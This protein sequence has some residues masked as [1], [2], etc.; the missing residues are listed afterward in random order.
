MIHA[1][2]LYSVNG[3]PRLYG[4]AAMMEAKPRWLVLRIEKSGWKVPNT[5]EKVT[6]R[7]SQ[8]VN[9]WERE[10]LLMKCK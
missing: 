8:N 2:R 7:D 10:L 3:I 5:W 6:L 4:P 9:K 1:N